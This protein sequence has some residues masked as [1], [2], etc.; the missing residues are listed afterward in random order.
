MDIMIGNYNLA[1]SIILVLIAV[2]LAFLFL[3]LLIR[4]LMD[5]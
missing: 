2:S 1:F 3:Y 4:D 5:K